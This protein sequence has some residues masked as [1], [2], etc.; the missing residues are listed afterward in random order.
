MNLSKLI[1]QFSLSKKQAGSDSYDKLDE[2]FQQNPIQFLIGVTK[3]FQDCD[4]NCKETAGKL[5]KQSLLQILQHYEVE[6]GNLNQ[7]TKEEIY[8]NLV[9]VLTDSSENIKKLAFEILSIVACHE[10]IRENHQ[11][12]TQNSE[13]SVWLE[14]QKQYQEKLPHYRFLDIILYGIQNNRNML[15][16]LTILN[17]LCDNWETMRLLKIEVYLR[18][19]QSKNFNGT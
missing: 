9:E 13:Q 7:G 5:L 10:N 18:L 6:W 8:F 2:L 14:F 16:R 12:F 17:L 11:K 1:E 15:V 4:M 19:E 3:I